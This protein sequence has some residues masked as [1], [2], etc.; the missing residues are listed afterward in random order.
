MRC[1]GQFVLLDI[2]FRMRDR[3]IDNPALD[4]QAGV[5]TMELNRGH[6]MQALIDIRQTAQLQTALLLGTRGCSTVKTPV[7]DHQAA[8]HVRASTALAAHSRRGGVETEA[9]FLNGRRA[10]PPT[11]DAST[12]IFLK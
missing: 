7:S 3:I 8:G 6:P 4:T 10:R 12:P 1:T 11:W 9:A 5:W 2:L